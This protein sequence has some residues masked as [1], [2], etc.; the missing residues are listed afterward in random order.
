MASPWLW[1][2]RIDLAVFGGS[3]AVALALLALKPLLAPEGEIGA[4]AFVAL[5]VAIDVA[6]VWST[7]F[8]TYLDRRELALR[9]VLYAGVPLACYVVGVALHAHS[10]GW[11]W[12]VLAYTAAFHFVR[13]QVGWVAIYRARAGDATRR[14]RIVDEIA[15]YAATL[16]PLLSWHTRLP[17]NFEWFVAGDFVSLPSAPWVGTALVVAWVLGAVLYVAHAIA[18]RARPNWGKHLVV[19][20]TYLTWSLGIVVTN[21]DFEFTVTNVIVHGVPY[22]ALLWFYARARFGGQSDGLAVSVLRV[23]VPAF[24]GFLVVLAALEELAWDRLVWHTRPT[25]FGV[26]A[27]ELDDLVT[28][29][30]VPL[31]ALPQATHYVL[32]AFLWRKRGANEAV[33]E[34][35]GFVR[36]RPVPASTR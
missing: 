22:F 12:R 3:T 21:S 1:G 8:R 10:P 6:H 31:L 26:G 18:D 28:A 15:I 20:S 29:L 13:Q 9:P 25:L 14:G 27:I 24:L 35:L 2:R 16:L 36:H 4:V 30:V 23:G 17:R 34:A 7:L 5:V 19:A 32:D 11:F 33:A